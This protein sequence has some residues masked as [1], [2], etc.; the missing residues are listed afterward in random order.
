MKMSKTFVSVFTVASAVV[1]SLG[2]TGLAKAAAT[3]VGLGAADGFAVLG[4]STVTN[5]GPT[6]INGDL[7]LSPGTS[8]TGFPPGVVNGV[9]H[10]TDSVAANA[11]SD[12]TTAFNSAAGEGPTSP[13]VGNLGGQT[14][15]AGVYNSGSS[16]GLT[17]TLT[18]DGQGN[19]NAVFVF[20]VGSALT[21]ASSSSVNLING[22]QACNVFWQIGSSA[23]LGTNSTFRGTVMAQA[24]VTVTTGARVEGRV[25]A[26]SGA[27]TL[28]TS[29]ISRAICAASPAPSP[30]SS[31]SSTS[32]STSAP[33]LPNVGGISSGG[34]GGAL[35]GIATLTGILVTMP[36]FY[37]IRR[38]LARADR[39]EQ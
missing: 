14:L 25:L 8:V 2:L 5:T 13:I 1:L 39:R 22:A 31:S 18:L 12:L 23:T 7:G 33:R 21:T 24:S 11:Q 29:I 37:L 20:Q 6:I 34:G 38:K 28:D 17:G 19:P 9:Q 16:V 36:S 15:T 30:S 10:I 26:R 35:L 27:I 4:A 32:T 3:S